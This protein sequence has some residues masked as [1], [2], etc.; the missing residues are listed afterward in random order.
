MAGEELEGRWRT[1][2]KFFRAGTR[3]VRM[4]AVTYGPFPGGWPASFEPDFARITAADLQ[5]TARRWLVPGK[6]FS[7]SVVPEKKLDSR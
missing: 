1:D 3:R 4:C 2:G 7:M 5:A 6:A